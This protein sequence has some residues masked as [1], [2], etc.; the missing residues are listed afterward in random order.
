M[1]SSGKSRLCD[2]ATAVAG[3]SLLALGVVMLVLPGPG[4]L[5]IV[6]ALALLGRS[7]PWA[8][9]VRERM[10]AAIGKRRAQPM[11]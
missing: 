1:C 8:R 10:I 4:V 5:L 11:G 2:L 6:G 3:W 9:R 7:L